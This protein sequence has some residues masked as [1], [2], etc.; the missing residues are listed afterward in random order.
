MTTTSPSKSRERDYK[1]DDFTLIQ[2]SRTVIVHLTKYLSQF[3]A[4]DSLFS[5]AFL[6]DWNNQIDVCESHPT[7][8]SM[9]DE[10]R[11][12]TDN[13]EEAKALCCKLSA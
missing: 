1:G 11:Q 3:S 12:Y 13:A 6:D 10:L 5:A 8:E 7:A 4:F 9:D 2:R